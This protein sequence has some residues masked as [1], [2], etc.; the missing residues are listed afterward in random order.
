MKKILAAAA[1]LTLVLTGCSGVTVSKDRY[2]CV[3]NYAT[4]ET[5]SFLQSKKEI[6]KAIGEGELD[7]ENY[8]DYGNDLEIGYVGGNVDSAMIFDAWQVGDI[9]CDMT[10]DKVE[11]IIGKPLELED[12]DEDYAYYAVD[13]NGTLSG[14][15]VFFMNII[16]NFRDEINYIYFFKAE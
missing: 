1:V 12:V 16:Y 8:Y 4:G 6:D 14:T 5:I 9:T 2:D 7:Y 15:P 3:T 13:E 11:S 10:R